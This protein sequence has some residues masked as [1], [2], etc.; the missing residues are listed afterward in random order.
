M[1]AQIDCFGEVR[2]GL[3]NVI[4][5]TGSDDRFPDYLTLCSGLG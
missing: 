5:I 4:T 2:D 1:Q 3:A